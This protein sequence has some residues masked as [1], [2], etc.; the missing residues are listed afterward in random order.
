M[1]DLPSSN[2][3]RSSCHCALREPPPFFAAAADAA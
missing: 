3:L 1:Y 2:A